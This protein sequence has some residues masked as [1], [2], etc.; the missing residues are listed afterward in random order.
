MSGLE[1]RRPDQE[2]LEEMGVFGWPI[3]EKGPSRF[4][5]SYG[6][7]EVCY[8]LQGRATVEPNEGEPVAIEAGDLVTFPQ[9]M[10]CTWEIHE[11][12]RKHYCLGEC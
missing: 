4:P 2:E 7:Q 11:A 3:W 5:W 12:V 9:G 8:L 10:G 6:E 1:V